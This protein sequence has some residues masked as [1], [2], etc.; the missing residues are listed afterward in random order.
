MKLRK[1]I[2]SFF[3]IVLL[4]AIGSSA[5]LA[6]SCSCSTL[7]VHAHEQEQKAIE[8]HALEKNCVGHFKQSCSCPCHELN[9]QLSLF[10]SLDDQDH[11]LQIHQ[12]LLHLLKA[13][14]AI[15]LGKELCVEH[16]QVHHYTPCN[17]TLSTRSEVPYGLRAPPHTI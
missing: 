11:N 6:F 1:F 16:T 12:Q 2:A 15:Y 17:L 13:L 3:L 8:Q 7:H 4:G 5:S 10:S 14:P 9:N